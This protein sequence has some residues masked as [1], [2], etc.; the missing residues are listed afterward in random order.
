MCIFAGLKLSLH[1]KIKYSV[2]LSYS[3]V[4]LILD[5]AAVKQTGRNSYAN[6][7]LKSQV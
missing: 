7:E 5:S 3:L 1:M 2:S 6:K 4:I